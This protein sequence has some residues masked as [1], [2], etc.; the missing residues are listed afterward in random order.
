LAATNTPHLQDLQALL[1]RE[2]ELQRQI[3]AAIWAA[4]EAMER[5][6]SGVARYLAKV[7]REMNAWLAHNSSGSFVPVPLPPELD[8]SH[9]LGPPLAASAQQQ[10]QLSAATGEFGAAIV[11]TAA[12]FKGGVRA[13]P[14]LDAAAGA[15]RPSRPSVELPEAC[16]D[17]G[18]ATARH[19]LSGQPG[20]N[21]LVR[22]R[23]GVSLHARTPAGVQQQHRHL[24]SCAES[25]ASHSA[26]EGG[27]STPPAPH[28]PWSATR[29]QV[30]P[31][32]GG[33]AADGEQG[34]SSSEG[35]EAEWAQP[36]RLPT[37]SGRAG[38]PTPRQPLP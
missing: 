35:S 29:N 38:P 37:I 1:D 26:G 12:A 2:L 28:R 18:A 8:L 31:W 11:V 17:S 16:N 6:S 9:S 36:A 7:T 23:G 19:I 4:V 14:G 34:S 13:E 30:V 33:G 3:Y 20:S 24:P 10:L 22:S 5:W 15:G 27:T 21:S 32:D 25:A